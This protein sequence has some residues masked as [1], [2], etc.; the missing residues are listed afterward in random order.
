MPARI[1]STDTFDAIENEC[2]FTRSALKADYDA[3]ALLSETDGWLGQVDAARAKDREFRV[4]DMEAMASRS[5]ANVRLDIS[6]LAFG[7]DLLY[8]VGD[9]KAPRFVGFFPIAPTRWVK[10][11]LDKQILG[12]KGWLTV[13]G[14]V[15]L[16]KHREN[17]GLRVAGASDSQVAVASLA[18]ARGLN[19][20]MRRDLADAMTRARD[21]LHR[22]LAELAEEKNLP[23][24]WPDAFFRIEE[25]ESP[26][27]QPGPP[28]V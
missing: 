26:P 8:A 1:N 10:Q 12:I 3:N 19:W 13:N 24:D 18:P 25:R 15:E 22:A 16:D 28:P 20:Q 7:K 5:I 4:A 23:R 14:D 2:M 17:L 11:G 9:R 6:C 27:V 21:G